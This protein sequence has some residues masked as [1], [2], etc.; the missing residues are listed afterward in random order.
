MTARGAARR[1]G[2]QGG[3]LAGRGGDRER[4]FT[5]LFASMHTGVY[6]T[7]T[8]GRALVVNPAALRLLGRDGE[9]LT[10]ASM[11][12]LVHYQSPTGEPQAAA[13]CPLLSVIVTGTPARSDDDDTFWRA[14]GMT[15]AVSAL[16]PDGPWP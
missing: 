15:V 4:L 13:G 2:T 6:A 11:P 5:S 8:D 10:G 14:A 1:H 12:G 7:D 16:V 9:D 3:T